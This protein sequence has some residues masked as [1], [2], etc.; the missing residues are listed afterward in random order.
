M[1]AA[2][3]KKRKKEKGKGI[4]G[5]EINR[6]GKGM[7]CQLPSSFGVSITLHMHPTTI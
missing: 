7:F 6:R 5:F 3:K 2:L 4:S 1:L